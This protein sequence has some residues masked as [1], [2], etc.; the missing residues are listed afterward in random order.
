MSTP[1]VSLQIGTYRL[2]ILTKHGR[3]NMKT[4]TCTILA[5]LSTISASYAVTLTQPIDMNNNNIVNVSNVVSSGG[6]QIVSGENIISLGYNE[7]RRQNR[8][9]GTV[10]MGYNGG[11]LSDASG[12]GALN[13]GYVGGA[14][15]SNAAYGD[16]AVNIGFCA[17]RNLADNHGAINMGYCGNNG[18][19]E[20]YG[21]GA[22]NM[23]YINNP[24]A[25]ND[26]SGSGS[27]NVGY[28]DGQRRATGDGSLTGGRTTSGDGNYAF[29]YGSWAV[30]CNA[31][32]SHNYAYVFG[33]GLQSR[34]ENS[35]SCIDLDVNGTPYANQSSF[36][37]YSDARLKENV[38]MIGNALDT[39]LRLR[40]VTFT[41][42]KT[43]GLPQGTRMGFIAQETETV[44]PSWVQDM[45]DGYKGMAPEGFEAL[46][47]EA[48]RELKTSVDIQQK[49]V[50]AQQKEIEQLRQEIAE[51]R[52]MIAK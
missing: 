49:K 22:I 15:C 41:Y 1:R 28:N 4:T 29:S 9:K 2:Y 34:R 45:G 26:A 16:G 43:K 35:L 21:Q 7:G 3:N 27:M 40:G 24:T 20:A 38:T 8:D 32:S 48:T 11:G 25:V 19:N 47:V 50:D 36:T 23:G 6:T 52:K 51:M 5:V 42:K 18:L 13:L 39:M 31:T 17:G 10:N 14:G 46:S 12:R 44:M 37:L 33:R 30:G